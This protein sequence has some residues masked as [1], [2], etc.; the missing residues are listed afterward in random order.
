MTCFSFIAPLVLAELS[1]GR[2]SACASPPALLRPPLK[3]SKCLVLCSPQTGPAASSLGK[4]LNP[5]HVWDDQMDLA[6][7]HNKPN[8]C[9][10]GILH[11]YVVMY[12][13]GRKVSTLEVQEQEKFS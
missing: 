3:A 1:A 5:G 9:P 13:V 6:V 4:E 11:L 7:T 10:V 2:K 12:L 8:P